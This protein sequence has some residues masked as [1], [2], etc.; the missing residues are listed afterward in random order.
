MW[1]CCDVGVLSMVAV[2]INCQI[3]PYIIHI[4]SIY[5]PYNMCSVSSSFRLVFVFISSVSGCV[6]YLCNPATACCPWLPCILVSPASLPHSYA[7]SFA[8]SFPVSGI[9]ASRPMGVTSYALCP[10]VRRPSGWWTEGQD[11]RPLRLRNAEK[12][13]GGE[14]RWS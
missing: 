6:S 2:D 7:V 13:G 1:R 3:Y 10:R 12:G 11:K 4:S 14:G 8:N 5:H 9:P